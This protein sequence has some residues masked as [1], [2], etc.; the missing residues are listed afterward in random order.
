MEVFS[1]EKQLKIKL[2]MQNVYIGPLS[3]NAGL[4]F[5]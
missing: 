2:E 3:S 5:I 4:S 1:Y